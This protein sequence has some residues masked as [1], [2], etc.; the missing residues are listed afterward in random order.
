LRETDDTVEAEGV[1]RALERAEA[2]DLT[3]VL[4]DA[5]SGDAG[6]RAVAHLLGPDSLAIATKTDV[7]SSEIPSPWLGVS[8][9]SGDGLPDLLRSLSAA[10]AARM[11][12]VGEVA[13]T[14]ARH[15]EAVAKAH[16]AVR[17]CR[18]ALDAG[19][20]LEIAAEDLRAAAGQLGRILG[21]VDVEEI[22][23]RLFAEFCLG[24]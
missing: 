22:L 19:D 9:R 23:D 17:R 20:P 3:L 24:K 15:R 10:V 14:R 4:A 13:L 2:A 1:R 21:R 18:T 6:R 16:E 5:Q 8:V 12:R 11:D 7:A